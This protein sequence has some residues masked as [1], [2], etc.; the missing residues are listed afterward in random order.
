MIVCMSV[1]QDDLDFYKPWA[2]EVQ[3]KIIKWSFLMR[4]STEN[5]GLG[6]GASEIFDGEQPDPRTF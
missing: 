6:E 5:A 2:E 4:S 1:K 3:G